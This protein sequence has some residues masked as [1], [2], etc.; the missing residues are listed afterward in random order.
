[1]TSLGRRKLWRRREG[2]N[3]SVLLHVT[4]LS[5]IG[6]EYHLLCCQGYTSRTC[7]W[8]GDDLVL[9]SDS[10]KLIWWS[11]SGEKRCEFKVGSADFIVRLDWSVSSHALWMCGFSSLSYLEVKRDDKGL[12]REGL[13]EEGREG[14]GEGAVGRKGR[15]EREGMERRL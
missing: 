1:M 8:D 14:G 5:R 10:G 7:A 13:R 15:G 9:P 6:P 12:L 11:L 4:K 2:G 3:I